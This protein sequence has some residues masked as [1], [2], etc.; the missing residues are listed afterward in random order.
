MIH[1]LT[2]V[3]HTA[4]LVRDLDQ[5]RDAWASLGFTLSP[6]GV[7]S[8]ARGTANHTIMLGTDYIELIGVIAPTEHNAP[9]RAFLT[10]GEGIER[11]GFRAL[12]AHAAA[13]ALKA[14][15]IAVLGP[16]DFGRP[17][18]FPN[19]QQAEARF[20]TFQWPPEHAPGGMRLFACQH[21]TP[22]HV[23][24]PALQQ[25][26]NTAL[27][28]LQI[29][30]LTPEPEQSAQEL[31]NLIGATGVNSEEGVFAVE[32]SPDRAVIAYLDEATAR[33]RYPAAWVADRRRE[34]GLALEVQVG[35][36]I[37]AAKETGEM[38]SGDRV[39]V[40]PAR[41]TGVIL[42]LVAA[43]RQDS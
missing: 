5:A 33:R 18:D 21:F 30:V 25:H 24:L 11:T 37:A 43:A 15:G 38:I 32:T 8:A 6:R 41:A 1:G 27:R 17:I 31:A 2:G 19:G 10:H 13:T 22:E 3:D 34:D 40:P 29:Q 36:L 26:P 7:H 39:L 23:W 4:V 16:Q 12:D 28:I 35:D 14:N 9:S 20:R 42:S